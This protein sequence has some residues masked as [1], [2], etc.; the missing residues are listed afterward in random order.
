MNRNSIRTKVKVATCCVAGAIVLSGSSFVSEAAVT[1]GASNFA[2]VVAGTPVEKTD[3]ATGAA[4]SLAE[5]LTEKA[6]AP[7]ATPQP[8]V[9]DKA[10]EAPVVKSEFADIG[11]SNVSEDSYINIRSEATTESEIVGKL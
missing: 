7:V 2:A 11:V 10:E 1:A 5:Y 4:L 6:N 3:T 8:E 9:Q